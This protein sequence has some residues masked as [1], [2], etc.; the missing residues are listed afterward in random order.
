[1]KGFC[2]SGGY[3][4]TTVFLQLL[5]SAANTC[6]NFVLVIGRVIVTV[7]P[8]IT[9]IIALMLMETASTFGTYGDH[10]QKQDYEYAKQY[11]SNN[12]QCFHDVQVS[13]TLKYIKLVVKQGSA[14]TIKKAWT[15][16][17]CSDLTQSRRGVI[18]NNT[19]V[20]MIAYLKNS[21]TGFSIMVLQK[22]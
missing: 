4:R 15:S 1:M 22:N 21:A 7:L 5:L 12:F 18:K 10:Y 6:M 14:R 8:Y 13:L 19:S 11:H 17:P 20:K 16:R 3:F 2:L 9:A